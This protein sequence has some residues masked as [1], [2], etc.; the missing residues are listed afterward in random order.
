[1][2]ILLLACTRGDATTDDTQL[3]A[4]CV[5]DT[6]PW[7]AGED[8]FQNAS[9][10]WGL[11]ESGIT[12][13]LFTAVDF[14]GDGW[15]DL[16]VRNHSGSVWLLRNT[17]DKSFE[18][19][20]EASGIRA[21]RKSEDP[22]PGQVWAWADV[23]NDGDLDVYTGLPDD[24]SSDETSELML[25]NGDGT[26]SLHSAGELRV[27]SADSPA[28][29]AF[30]DIDRDGFVDL[31]VTQS[32]SLGP[33]QDRLYRNDG[34][35]TYTDVTFAMGL[36]TDRWS[37]IAAAD[38]SSHTVAWGATACDLDDDGDPELMSSS[39]G[40]SPNHLW[41]N[42]G[43][44]FTNHSV[45]SGYAYDDRVD[46]SDNESARCYCK[47]NQQLEECV[48]VPEPALIV[49]NSA[50][51]AFRWNHT[52]DREPGR[53]G[54]NSGATMCR[55]VDGDG[56]LDLLTTEIVHW[57]VGSSSD[58][59]ELLFNNGDATFERP[60]NET[61]G[62]TR[63]HDRVDWNDGDITGSLFDFD[64]D[65]RTDVYIGNTDYPGS[66]GLLW[67]NQGDRRFSAVP[68]ED[69][70][71]HF[72][73]HGSVVADFDRDGDLDLVLGHS[74]SRCDEDCYDDR[75]LRMFE[76]VSPDGNFVQLELVGTTANRAA[77]GARVEV[78]TDDLLQVV[79][80]DGGHGHYGAQDDL[81]LHFGLGS[82][83]SAEVTVRWPD[84]EGSEQTVTLLS[85]HRFVLEQGGEPVK[86]P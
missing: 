48:G 6:A 13:T 1:M 69:G 4:V 63:E 56:H 32:Y 17:G 45:A 26:F 37:P 36:D 68:L 76:N 77:I 23:D 79:E 81:V 59:A 11:A 73:S 58:P 43:D 64:N 47:Y 78:R 80:V 83:C 22:R 62:L 39:Y 75:S 5:E 57:D 55:D 65:G 70:I 60:G 8:V 41:L 28:G 74:G 71:D 20:T 14:D 15:A 67:H 9:E 66:R 2:L 24:G 42:E 21:A 10:T 31:W 44:A 84:A 3:E 54:G 38:G 61:T 85:G 72:R 53:L 25:N 82:A 18:D 19:V 40:R 49:C 27:P 51:D 33:I 12:G 50:G 34:D 29:A 52:Y 30:T 16:A 35:G 7:S 86:A 46:W